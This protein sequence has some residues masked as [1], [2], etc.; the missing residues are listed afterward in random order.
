MQFSEQFRARLAHKVASRIMK[1]ISRMHRRHH[2]SPVR[3]VR[4]LPPRWAFA[5]P[6]VYDPDC[7]ICREVKHVDDEF[8]LALERDVKGD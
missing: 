3:L 8:L 4:F 1:E 6:G 5:R 2:Q 7:P